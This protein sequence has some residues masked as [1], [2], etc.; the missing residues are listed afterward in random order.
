[1]KKIIALLLLLTL[2]FSLVA[3]NK[4][5]TKTP[6]E[7]APEA[8]AA[9]EDTTPEITAQ[10]IYDANHIP[11][12]LEKY[13]NIYIENA[14]N[15]EVYKEEYFSKDYRYYHEFYGGEEY[16]VLRTDRA[17]YMY[18]DNMY[19]LPVYITPDGMLDMKQAFAELMDRSSF[20]IDFLNDVILS[21]TEKDGQIVVKSVSDAEEQEFYKAQGWAVNEEDHVLDAETLNVISAKGS[22]TNLESGETL[23]GTMATFYNVEMPEKMKKLVEFHTQTENL[24]TFTI[25]INPGEENEKTE[26]V[27]APKGLQIALSSD[28]DVERSYSLYDDASC[29]RILEEDWDTESDVTVYVKWDEQQAE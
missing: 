16:E 25:V 24:R 17:Y 4:E 2:V 9:P 15:G 20:S 1:M 22:Y 12:L 10:S 19:M 5:E 23:E 14:E 3:C 28:L 21:V 11:T 27:K 7:V 29:T 6:E 8:T 26:V 13:D 18:Y